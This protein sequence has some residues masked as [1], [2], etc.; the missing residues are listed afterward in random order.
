MKM[1]ITSPETV[2]ADALSG[3]A[4]AHPELS[5]DVERRVGRGRSWVTTSRRWTWRAAR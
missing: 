4:V 5:V 2:V 1:L 3:V